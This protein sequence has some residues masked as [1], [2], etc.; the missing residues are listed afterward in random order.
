M[1]SKILYNNIIA[2]TFIVD[3]E[4]NYMGIEWTTDLSEEIRN[5]IENFVCQNHLSASNK[6]PA[7]NI[8]ITTAQIS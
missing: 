1:A 7:H 8:N 5:K 4:S 3:S 2:G 6:I